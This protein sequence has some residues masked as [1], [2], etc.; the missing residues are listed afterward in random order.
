MAAPQG[1]ISRLM[2]SLFGSVHW[3]PP[4][5]GVAL[6]GWSRRHRPGLKRTAALML[7]LLLALWAGYRYWQSLPQPAL[8]HI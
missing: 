5:W 8:T 6:A 3:Q 4:S 1:F 7:L 2:Q